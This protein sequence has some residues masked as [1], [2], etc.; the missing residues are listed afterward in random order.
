MDGRERLWPRSGLMSWEAEGRATTSVYIDTARR[1]VFK[2][3]IKKPLTEVSI[4]G[5][6][7]KAW[8]CPTLTWGSPTLPSAMHRFTSEFE[9]GSG[10]SS[11]LLP[12]GKPFLSCRLK[13]GSESIFLN[14]LLL[15]L[16][17]IEN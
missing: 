13:M 10:G 17:R 16:S 12:P 2:P 11:T 7:F 5:Y 14:L 6:L 3:S 4:R 15:Q 9:M 8:Q 1:E